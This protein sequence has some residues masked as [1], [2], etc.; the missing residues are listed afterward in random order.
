M[1]LG[2]SDSVPHKGF[3][4]RLC[5]KLKRLFHPAEEAVIIRLLQDQGLKHWR[6]YAAAFACMSIIAAATAGVAW[7]MRDVLDKVFI[8]KEIETV[9]IVAAFMLGLSIAKGL[10]S[11]GQQVILARVANGIVADLQKR[12]YD[13][14]LALSVGY[15]GARHSS[16]FI[17]RQ[18]FMTQSASSALNLLVTAFARDLL[19]L[20]S[21]AAVMIMQDPLL[22]MFALIIMPVAIIGT[23][24][25]SGR[26][27]KIVM[28]EFAG[29]SKIMESLQ[30]TAQGIRIVKAFT[31]EPQ[32]RQK[33]HFA[34]DTVKKAANRTAMVSA[35]SSPLMETLGGFAI[36][37]VVVY[38]GWRVIVDGHS[39]GA[40]FSFLTALLL[41]Y[42]PAKRLARLHI[43]LNGCLP[44]V[45]MVYAF[46]EEPSVEREDLD[47]PALVLGA[48]R[49]EVRD[50]N[51]SYK[52]GE[53]VLCALSL[54]AEAGRTTALV[55]R[56]GSG[57]STI[58][59]L[60]LRY[61]DLGTG[62]ILIDGQDIAR[63]SRAS[64]R[65]AVSYVSQ[66]TFLFK[67][68]IRENIALGRAGAD[69]DE[70]IAAAK[71]ACAHDFITTF[72]CGYDTQCGEHGMQLSGG[73]RQRIA[74]ARAF[75]KN[76]PILLLDEATSALDTEAE[77][78][79]QDALDRLQEGR[80]TLVIAHRLS[81]VRRADMICVIDRGH[82]IEAGV[83]DDLVARDDSLYGAM[84]RSQ[85]GVNGA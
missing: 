68:T 40:F 7:L 18:S 72:E 83:H 60:I 41:A 12:I 26:V 16:Q 56:S 51:F 8:G 28:T 62:A 49:I 2:P 58:M 14:M 23:R 27:R 53:P 20:L 61:W 1:T 25:L 82:L 45:A 81:T 24:Y 77:R 85:V 39:P 31:L 73:Q 3:I 70:I 66:E 21:L 64:L 75:L 48:G 13:K 36:A 84:V 22:S 79:I 4:N 17:A 42:E 63:V 19:M 35:R 52:V 54:C 9:W 80:T 57:K 34:I 10:G 65:R 6:A 71:A 50:V 38:G 46:L 15:F 74:I 55:G 43:D 69:E 30:E 44:G 76:A 33:Q 59:S 11:Y 67:G 78:E 5:G 32:S 37:F 29:F 47:A